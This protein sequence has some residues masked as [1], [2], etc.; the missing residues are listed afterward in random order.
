MK[1]SFIVTVMTFLFS[2]GMAFASGSNTVHWGYKGPGSPEN[3]GTISPAYATCGVGTEQSPIDIS[4]EDGVTDAVQTNYSATALNVLNN[5]HTIQLNYAAGST[6]Q[7]AGQ[8]YDLLQLH[9]HSPSEHTINGKSYPL[10]MHLVHKAQDGTLAVVG[11]MFEEGAENAELAKIWQDMPKKANDVVTSSTQVDANNLLPANQAFTRYDGSLTTPPCSE[12]VKWHVMSSPLQVS[13]K[14][15]KE[16]LSR[17][18]ENARP[19]QPLNGRKLLKH[20]P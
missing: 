17:V 2:T 16:F 10:E 6:L 5:G 14:Q 12:G 9:F 7:S 4:Q 8:H 13:K 1:K 18:H 11:V 15:V 3:W 19:V 20:T